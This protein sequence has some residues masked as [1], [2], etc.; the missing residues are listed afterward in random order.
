VLYLPTFK[1]NYQLQGYLAV[2]VRVVV[3]WS[4]KSKARQCGQEES[5]FLSLVE[6]SST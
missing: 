1:N 3:V 2:Y 6:T 4:Q 5:A